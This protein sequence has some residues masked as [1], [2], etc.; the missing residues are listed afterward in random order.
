MYHDHDVK[1]GGNGDSKA[2]IGPCNQ[3]DTKGIMSYGGEDYNTWSSC[4]KSNFEDAY[5]SNRHTCFED[6]SGMS[7]LK[8]MIFIC[9]I[10][11]ISYTINENPTNILNYKQIFHMVRA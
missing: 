6:I 8:S 10:Y 7:L 11:N 3:V 9:M 5:K 1:N 2:P 4:S